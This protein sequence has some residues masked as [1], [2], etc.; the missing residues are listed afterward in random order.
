MIPTQRSI[1][2]IF[3]EESSLS[4]EVLL[5]PLMEEF[6]FVVVKKYDFE[7]VEV[8]I[9]SGHESQGKKKT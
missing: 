1:F 4:R 3:L 9:D 5:Q 2:S 8:N 6:K 7:N